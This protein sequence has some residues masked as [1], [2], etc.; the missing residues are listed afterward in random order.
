MSEIL[1]ANSTISHYRIIRK[2]G[3]GGM[4]EVYLADDTRLDRKVAL[5]ILPEKISANP[6]GLNRF[7]QEA[8]SASALNQPNIITVY[9]IGEVE[10]KHFI[11][12]EF[13]DGQTLRARMKHRLT[14]DETLPICIQTAEA[15]SAAHQ[16]GIVHRDIK[17][18]NIM[19]RTE[20]SHRRIGSYRTL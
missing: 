15:L 13:I 12:I 16:V 4:G 17:P 1:S 3:S 19:I 18:E 9:E 11:A 10:G 2:I 5:K 20:I 14:F 8:K 7:R 6:E